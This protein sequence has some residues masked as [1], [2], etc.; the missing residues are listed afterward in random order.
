MRLT[1]LY[2]LCFCFLIAACS[3]HGPTDYE[4]ETA[5]LQSKI[6]AL[7]NPATKDDALKLVYYR[8]QLAA[9]SGDYADFKV[10]EDSITKALHAHGP[11]D[12]LLYFNA[13]LHFKLHRFNTAREIIAS[14]PLAGE[15]ASLRALAADLDLQ[16]GRYAEALAEYEALAAENPG[17]DM[18]ARLAYYRLKTGHPE[19]AD[20][21]YRRAA[22][23]IPAKDMRAYAWIELQRG[24]VDLEYGRPEE[25]LAH[26]RLADRAW[27]GYWLIEEH[28]AE[29]LHLTGQTRRAIALY[30]DIIERTHNPEFMTALANILE[31]ADPE[32]ATALYFEADALYRRQFEL[33]PE[34]T[35]GHLIEH[36][37][38]K[39]DSDPRL[40]EYAEW[41]HAL[42]P[43]AEAKLLLAR[44]YLKLGDVVA[45]RALIDEILQ[46][47]WRTPELVTL[48]MNSPTQR[49]NRNS[50]R[51]NENMQRK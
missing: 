20:E 45:A 23:M 37:L 39:R 49:I 14:M 11:V 17:W 28:I 47:P 42:R 2:S 35:A 29:A 38:E 32:A 25:A 51:S 27:S 9:L 13:H 41:N 7:P 34:A 50:P 30:R 22:D 40:R 43:N 5:A 12:D 48:T 33:Y 15:S 36:L 46:T 16:Q 31:E 24:L 19:E 3:G 18:L 44:S 8:Y 6:E 21:L 10:A 26:Y 1:K 4:K